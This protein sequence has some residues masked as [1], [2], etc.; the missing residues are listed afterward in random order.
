MFNP[1]V[2][3]RA[4][5]AAGMTV[6]ATITT[7]SGTA[8]CDVGFVRPD[9]LTMDGRVQSTEFEIELLDPSD[10]ADIAEGD[11]VVIGAV[12]YTVRRA[13]ANSDP[14]ADGTFRRVLLS[15]VRA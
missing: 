13:P 5:K 2:F 9:V 10:A 11:D 3:R 8:D 14:G 6:V 7:A 15:K 1:A 4:F 12:A